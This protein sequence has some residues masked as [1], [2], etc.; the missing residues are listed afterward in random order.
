MYIRLYN[1]LEMFISLQNLFIEK[2]NDALHASLHF[3]IQDSN[4]K[5]LKKMFEGMQVSTGKLNFISIGSKF[6][7]QLGLL[8]EKLKS[9]V[10]R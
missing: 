4:N 10:C 9:T 8:M 1:A 2:N 7:S 3:L 5:L 6:R